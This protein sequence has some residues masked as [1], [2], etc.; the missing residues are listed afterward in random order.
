MSMF[1]HKITL[2]KKN[3]D[4]TYQPSQII[5]GVYWDESRTKRLNGKEME[6]GAGVSI[7][8]PISKES[9]F[10]LGDLVLKGEYNLT[11]TSIS[12]LENYAYSTIVSKS[13]YDV[14]SNID[15]VVLQCQ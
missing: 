8:A 4:G 11:I 5:S 2:I 13:V 12:G 9:S 1:P 3:S 7:Y 15:N 10:T 14:G 6:K